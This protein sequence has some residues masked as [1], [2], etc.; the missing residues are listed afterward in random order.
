MTVRNLEEDEAAGLLENLNHMERAK[1]IKLMGTR[2]IRACEESLSL[3]NEYINV[4]IEGF[5]DGNPSE[6]D[7][8]LLRQ[9]NLDC[10]D[11][12]AQ[13]IRVKMMLDEDFDKL[14]LWVLGEAEEKHQA[15]V[16]MVNIKREVDDLARDVVA[17]Q[18]VCS[19]LGAKV[20]KWRKERREQA[21]LEPI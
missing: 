5:R 7:F 8:G 3:I 13:L 16:H 2:T 10:G 19:E 4:L 21:R 6:G 15:K 14:S 12:G 9:V 20:M 17:A 1:M 11:M 18:H